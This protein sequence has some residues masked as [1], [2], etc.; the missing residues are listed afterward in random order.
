M[1]HHLTTGGWTYDWLWGISLI[2]GSA[3]LHAFGLTLIAQGMQSALDVA[4]RFRSLRPLE[5]FSAAITATS[6]SLVI[7]H[8]LE[9]ALW[10]VVL[11]WLDACPNFRSAIYFSLQMATTLGADIVQLT[12]PWKL[13]GPLEGVSGMLMFGISTAFLFAVIR[14]VWPYPD[15]EPG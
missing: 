8:G 9:A 1:Q 10:A 2:V 7:L 12:D 14:R 15:R 11:V 3:M 6:L 4:E 13:M 5:R